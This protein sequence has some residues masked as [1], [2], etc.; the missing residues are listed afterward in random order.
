MPDCK[1]FERPAQPAV[2]M[3][4]TV[5]VDKLK[6]FLPRAFGAILAYIGEMG[7]Q[8]AGTPFACYHNMDVQALDVEAGFPV[9]R[10]LPPRGEML[11]AE[12]PAGQCAGCMHVGSY[13]SL[14]ATYEALA[15]W[16]AERKLQPTGEAYEY[17]H[18]GPETPPEQTL[19]Q[20]VFPLKA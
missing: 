20:I 2:T 11:A 1:L 10:A 5:P 3:R 15:R 12:I 14:S 13:E 16:V 9:S 19:T 6:D 7:A 4:T 18:T 8:P 17:Y